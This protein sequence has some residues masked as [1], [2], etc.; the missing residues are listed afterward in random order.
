MYHIKAFGPFPT[1]LL[2][3]S[4]SLNGRDYIIINPN[5]TSKFNIT[6]FLA[7]LSIEI[8]LMQTEATVNAALHSKGKIK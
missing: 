6:F 7:L 5:A 3:N 4:A 1:D 8:I 2:Q